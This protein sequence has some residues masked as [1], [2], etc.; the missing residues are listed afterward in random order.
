MEQK[1]FMNH[2]DF[3]KLI[4]QTEDFIEAALTIGRASV[5]MN[6]SADNVFYAMNEPLERLTTRLFE[7]WRRETN[8]D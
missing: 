2:H 1:E 7:I 5:K 3:V 8:N 6:M 4:E